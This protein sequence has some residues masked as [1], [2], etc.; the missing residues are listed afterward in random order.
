MSRKTKQIIFFALLSQFLIYS[1]FVYKSIP[2]NNVGTLSVNSQKGKLIFQKYNC[3]ACHQ[4]YGLGGYMGPDLT[5]V[6]NTKG[7]GKDYVRA[8]ITSGTAKMPNFHIP[9]EE[10]ELL[11]SYLEDVSKSGVS[12]TVDFDI[13]KDGTVTINK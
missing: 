11:V 5:N 13:N 7:K 12:P 4:L 1:L 10:I 8:F 2:I 3:I 6:M 9:Q